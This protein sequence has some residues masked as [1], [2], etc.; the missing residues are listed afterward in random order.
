M[1]IACGRRDFIAGIASI[2]AASSLARAQQPDRKRI[3]VLVGLPADDSV[4]AAEMTAFVQEL[5]KLGCPP[6]ASNSR[7]AGPV[8]M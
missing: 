2:A 4:G 3:G 7:T 1:R 8:P 6:A 5:D